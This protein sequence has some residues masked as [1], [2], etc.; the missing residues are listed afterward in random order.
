MIDKHYTN[1]IDIIN[2]SSV[3]KSIPIIFFII[4]ITIIIGPRCLWQLQTQ[5]LFVIFKIIAVNHYREFDSK[6]NLNQGV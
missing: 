6:L 4:I 2:G 3:T 5:F 1:I